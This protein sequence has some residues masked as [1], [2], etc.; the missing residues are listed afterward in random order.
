VLFG[1]YLMSAE[2]Q[3]AMWNSMRVD[4]DEFPESN[5]AKIIKSYEMKGTVFKKITADWWL[6]HPE[7]DNSM[8]NLLRYFTVTK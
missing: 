4:L 5:S 1:L 2:G 7:I 3:A 8:K 6:S